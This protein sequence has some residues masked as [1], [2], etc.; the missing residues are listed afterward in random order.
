MK[1][2]LTR[3]IRGMAHRALSAT[4]RFVLQGR[5]SV[6]SVDGIVKMGRIVGSDVGSDAGFALRIGRS[7]ESGDV[8]RPLA[9]AIR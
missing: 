9:Q 8:R 7:G 2:G 1:P 3:A 4:Y 5:S 6:R